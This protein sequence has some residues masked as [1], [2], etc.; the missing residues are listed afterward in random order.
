MLDVHSQRKQR[1]KVRDF[2]FIVLFALFD[3]TFIFFQNAFW[4]PEISNNP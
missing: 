4:I 1:T 3:E 2:W